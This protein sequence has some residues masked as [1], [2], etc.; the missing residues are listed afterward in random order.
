MDVERQGNV[1][2]ISYRGQLYKRGF[3]NP[4][5][6]YLSAK[7]EEHLL[8]EI[9][10]GGCGAHTGVKDLVRK[11]IRVGFYWVKVGFMA[12]QVVKRCQSCQ[13]HGKIIHNSGE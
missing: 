8:H 2:D 3:S 10:A 7:D 6:K 11:V 12:T 4:H 5:L 13:K 1:C 9:Q